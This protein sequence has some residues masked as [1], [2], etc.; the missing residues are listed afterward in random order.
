M[1]Y[2]YA[3]NPQK[4]IEYILKLASEGK[5]RKEI[6]QELGYKAT[7]GLYNFTKRHNYNWNANKG[8]YVLKGEKQE[9]TKVIEETETL[10][11]K[12]ASII[13]MFDKKI[14]G[15]EI[16]KNLKFASYQDMADY[17]KSKG[18]VWDNSNRN[19]IKEVIKATAPQEHKEVVEATKSNSNT[20]NISNTNIDKYA[21]TL[22]WITAN[23]N[24]L[25]ELLAVENNDLSLPRYAL[26]GSSTPKTVHLNNG[27]DSLIKDFSDER[28][29]NQREIIK[30]ALIEFLKKH[31]YSEQVKSVLKV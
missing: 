15:K 17:M 24:K 2:A 27:L 26:Q 14:D 8:L 31:G 4:K 30:I 20:T 5:S 25:D 16:A 1:N 9:Y 3:E 28:N 7:D 23:R 19:Y 10:P 13:T 29:I 18:F 6:A 21:D 11:S 12:I 22:E